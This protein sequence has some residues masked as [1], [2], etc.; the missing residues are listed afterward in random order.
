MKYFVL[1]AALCV[2]QVFAFGINTDSIKVFTYAKG[3]NNLH[4]LRLHQD[5]HYEHLLCTKTS[6]KVDT[7]C[8]MINRLKMTFESRTKKVGSQSMRDVVLYVRNNK[9][10]EKRWEAILQKNVYAKP[11]T[12]SIYLKSYDFNPLTKTFLVVETKPEKI[13][14]KPDIQD[15]IYFMNLLHQFAPRYEK[16]IDTNYCGPGCYLSVVGNGTV[17]PSKDTTNDRLINSF[18]TMVHETTHHF[19]TNNTVIIDPEI[20]INFPKIQTYSSQDFYPLIKDEAKTKIFRL[21]TYI[22]PGSIV[23][24]NLS[25]IIGLMD[26]FSAYRNGTRASLDA[27]LSAKAQGNKERMLDFLHEALPSYFACYEFQIFISWY[28]DYGSKNRAEFHR[29]LMANTNFRVAFTLLEQGFME[30]IKVMEKLVK[31]NPSVQWNYDFYEKEH[32]AF[33][34]ELLKTQD[35]ILAKFR[36]PGVTK[37]NYKSYLIPK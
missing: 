22:A 33:C 25:G 11:T 9:L 10:Y 30:D 32:A 7:G 29:S 1:T 19:N 27:A 2:F 20:I 16:Y 36:I 13:I 6:V 12:D 23:S 18:N 34:K 21:N 31:E 8:F 5:G 26:E 28:L 37:S 17:V 15:K 24:A 3:K 4:V 35:K 14:E